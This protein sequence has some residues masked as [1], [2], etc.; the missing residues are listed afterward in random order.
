[1]YNGVS[2]GTSERLPV[3][4]LPIDTPSALPTTLTSPIQPASGLRLALAMLLMTSLFTGIV[5][6]VPRI[7]SSTPSQKRRPARVTTKEGSPSSVMIR[8]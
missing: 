3:P 1:M 4:S 7:L 2:K 5:P 6:P 8:P